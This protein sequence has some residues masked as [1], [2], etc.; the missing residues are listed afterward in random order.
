MEENQFPD[1][2]I[3]KQQPSIERDLFNDPKFIRWFGQFKNT[4]EVSSIYEDIQMTTKDPVKSQKLINAIYHITI[5]N[6]I[7]THKSIQKTMRDEFNMSGNLNSELLHAYALE[8]ESDGFL[9]SYDETSA[10]VPVSNS[11]DKIRC[12]SITGFKEFKYSFHDKTAT[13]T[14][15]KLLIQGCL[16][17]N[18]SDPSEVDSFVMRYILDINPDESDANTHDLCEYRDSGKINTTNDCKNIMPFKLD[19]FAIGD[20]ELERILIDKY[21][22][23]LEKYNITDERIKKSLVQNKDVAR[24]ISNSKT[25]ENPMYG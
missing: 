14:E 24:W 6:L 25:F 18:R 21:K 7:K 5:Y 10:K 19:S 20:K 12:K 1:G 22:C 4:D 16:H 2:V 9:I 13:K 15:E 3:Y 17:L 23:I 8:K 11:D